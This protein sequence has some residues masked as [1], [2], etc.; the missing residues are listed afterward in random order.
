MNCFAKS[1]FNVDRLF[2]TDIYS[3]SEE[4]I[5]GIHALNLVNEIKSHGLKDVS[6]LKNLDDFYENIGTAK[7]EKIIIITM[8]AGDITKFSYSLVEFL[9]SNQTLYEL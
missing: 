9:K 3:A 7:G 1:F 2:I 8:G 4:P 5:I 6:Y